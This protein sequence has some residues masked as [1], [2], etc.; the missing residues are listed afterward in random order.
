MQKNKLSSRNRFSERLV[1]AMFVVVITTF[2]SLLCIDYY[3]DELVEITN[4]VKE[5]LLLLLGAIS[6]KIASTILCLV[7]LVVWPLESTER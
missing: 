6:I 3:I 5:R 2:L 4:I 7:F 1:N